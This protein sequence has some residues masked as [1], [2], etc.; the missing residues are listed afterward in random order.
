[1]VIQKEKERTDLRSAGDVF[2]K[3]IKDSLQN[4]V[5]MCVSVITS[6]KNRKTY[7]NFTA[8]RIKVV[9]E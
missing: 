4:K 6:Q 3:G 5:L 7:G 9:R 1:M 2:R 8:L